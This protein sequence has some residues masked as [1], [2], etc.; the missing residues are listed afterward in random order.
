[1]VTP[2]GSPRFLSRATFGRSKGKPCTRDPGTVGSAR[3][4]TASAVSLPQSEGGE[5]ARG[6]EPQGAGRRLALAEDIQ[7]LLPSACG[8]SRRSSLSSVFRSWTWLGPGNETQKGVI[9]WDN[10]FFVSRLV[11]FRNYHTPLCHVNHATPEILP[12]QPTM[13]RKRCSVV[14]LALLGRGT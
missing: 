7:G 1:M 2:T 11:C 4:G 6:A 13:G 10:P 5:P 14:L 9:R 8:A 12:Q 3:K